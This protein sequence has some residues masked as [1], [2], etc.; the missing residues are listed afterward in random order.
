VVGKLKKRS[1][2]YDAK[3]IIR[4]KQTRSDGERTEARPKLPFKEKKAPGRKRW[5]GLGKAL[6]VECKRDK[7]WGLGPKKQFAWRKSPPSKKKA[8]VKRKLRG[9]RMGFPARENQTTNEERK[10]KD[11]TNARKG[12]E[13]L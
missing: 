13:A 9:R 7:N 3:R 8:R 6:K 2:E 10:K 5:I 1:T 12:N 4:K 11:K